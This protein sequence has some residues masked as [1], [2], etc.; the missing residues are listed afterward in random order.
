MRL[1]CRTLRKKGKKTTKSSN[2]PLCPSFI[3]MEL[4]GWLT[5]RM[6]WLGLYSR[7]HRSLSRGALTSPSWF[8][9]MLQSTRSTRTLPNSNC[10]SSRKKFPTYDGFTGPLALLTAS[11]DS[12][13]SLDEIYIHCALI[14]KASEAI[15]YNLLLSPSFI[16]FN[17]SQEGSLITGVCDGVVF[18]GC[19]LTFN[20]VNAMCSSSLMCFQS[21]PPL[22]TLCHFKPFFQMWS[23]LARRRTNGQQ[24]RH[25]VRRASR[26]RFLSH[27]SKL[28]L[29]LRRQSTRESSWRRLLNHHR[30]SL[31][32]RRA[33]KVGIH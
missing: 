32:E 11:N 22:F 26:N 13:V 1:P 15:Q 31:K 6:A 10:E 5:A 28:L 19:C 7:E 12:S 8:P 9:R 27:A 16:A 3:R 18:T 29:P 17:K 30:L 33:T 2:F 21:D 4:A 20:S 24:R 23:R 25:S 14:Y